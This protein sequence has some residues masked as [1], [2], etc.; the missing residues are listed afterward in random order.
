MKEIKN[1]VLV[2]LAVH[3]YDCSK[4][5]RISG[6]EQCLLTMSPARFLQYTCDGMIGCEQAFPGERFRTSLSE[7]VQNPASGSWMRVV[8]TVTLAAG[9]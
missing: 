3:I 6:H 7:E 8:D 4:Q 2:S 1:G 5:C 9:S